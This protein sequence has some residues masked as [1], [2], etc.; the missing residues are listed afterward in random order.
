MECSSK[1]YDGWYYH[2]CQRKATIERD[3]KWYCPSHDPEA[4]KKRKAKTLEKRKARECDKCGWELKSYWSYCPYCG[5]KKQLASY[6]TGTS[7]PVSA[8]Q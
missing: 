4:I 5:T 3:G 6:P 8:R 2:S 7:P 1:T